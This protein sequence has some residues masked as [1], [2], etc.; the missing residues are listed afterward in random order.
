MRNAKRIR[1]FRIGAFTLVE[2]IVVIT[3][4][5]V[6]ATIGFLSLSGYSSDAKDVAV[7]SNVRSVYSA[8]VS[9]AA[10]TGNSP[11]YYVIHDPNYALSGG[12]VVFDGNSSSLA[13]GDWN[14]PGTNY[15]A[16]N[17]DYS[18]LR[19]NREKFKISRSEGLVSD[20]FQKFQAFAATNADPTYLLV[21]AVDVTRTVEGKTKIRSYG[22]VAG[23]LPSK[24]ET[25]IGD[26]PSFAYS[27]AVL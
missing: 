4:L 6:L 2:L 20:V 27:G 10:L 22:Q 5:A 11:R 12:V 25:V 18:K 26:Y 19:I 17:P 13:G 14:Q 21:G 9:E 23:L 16:G 3:I 7:K 24:T 1:R 8:I 15:S